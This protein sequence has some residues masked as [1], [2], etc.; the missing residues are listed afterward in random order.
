MKRSRINTP[1]KHV[2][3]VRIKEEISDAETLEVLFGELSKKPKQTDVLLSYLRE[4]PAVEN[5]ELNQ[6]GNAKIQVGGRVEFFICKYSDQE[7]H[8][9]AMGR[10]GFSS[11]G[12]F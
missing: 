6:K 3:K 10:G 12:T 1:P 5:K 11:A 8:F 7:W 9:G 2:K 4:I